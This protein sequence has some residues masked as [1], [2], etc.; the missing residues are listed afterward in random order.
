MNVQ[1]FFFYFENF[2]QREASQS[3]RAWVIINYLRGN[4]LQFFYKR[5]APDGDLTIEATNYPI[6]KNALMERFKKESNLQQ[7]IEKAVALTIGD[8]ERLTSFFQKEEAVYRES[9]FTDEHIF[10]FMSKAAIRYEQ[11]HNY[12]VLHSSNDFLGLKRVLKDFE[13]TKK[14]FSF[15]EDH[16]MKRP[17]PYNFRF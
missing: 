3:E 17:Q 4:S 14:K 2:A 9:K 5:F 7:I 16:S 12:V 8:G 15:G 11:L 1:Y 10:V 13:D 6:L